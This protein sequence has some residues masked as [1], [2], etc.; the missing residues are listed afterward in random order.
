L[1]SPTRPEEPFHSIRSRSFSN[2]LPLTSSEAASYQY[3]PMRSE[4]TTIHIVSSR[5]LQAHAEAILQADQSIPTWTEYQESRSPCW[6]CFGAACPALGKQSIGGPE[7]VGIIGPSTS[8]GGIQS[9]PETPSLRAQGPT[10][11]TEESHRY[12][13]TR[14]RVP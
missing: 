13:R 7:G 3:R 8:R 12:W 9:C 4:A 6:R 11:M 5:S 1:P 14:V 2:G 10:S